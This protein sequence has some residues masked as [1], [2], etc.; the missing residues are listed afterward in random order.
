MIANNKSFL[1][2]FAPFWWSCKFW[3]PKRLNHCFSWMKHPA[4]F[5]I[6]LYWITASL[7]GVNKCPK[8]QYSTF[9]ISFMLLFN[10]NLFN[11]RCLRTPENSD[12]QFHLE[13]RGPVSMKGK[14]EPMQVW[15]L[16]R[17]GTEVWLTKTFYQNKNK[18]EVM[19]GLNMVWVTK[20]CS[21][22]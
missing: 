11:F 2:L 6:C 3:Q 8:I 16:S 17:K 20:T 1:Q 19:R 13:H 10:Y 12:P 5:Q 21:S 14:K 7:N 22:K 4:L 18:T 9:Y 15:F